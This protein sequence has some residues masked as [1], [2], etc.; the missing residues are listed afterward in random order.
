M[1]ALVTAIDLAVAALNLV[2]FGGHALFPFLLA[3]AGNEQRRLW[4]LAA[5][6]LLGLSAIV[7]AW[8]IGQRPDEA[9]AWGL[10]HPLTGSAP[11]RMIAV[12]FVAAALSDLLTLVLW[13]KLEPAAWRVHGAIGAIALLAQ[14]LGAELLRI[15]WGPS[16]AT[17]ALLASAALRVP[18]ALAAAEVAIGAPR[19]FALAA[20][21]ALVLLAL[22]WP[23]AMRAALVGDLATL[24]A[25]VGLLALARF[26]PLSLRRPAAIAGVVLALLFL[27]RSAE[28]SSV[29]GTREQLHE[30]EL[31]P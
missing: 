12:A 7:T 30:F 25:A 24:A 31:A 16:G 13:P 6:P 1:N 17:W 5:L 23:Q 28:L 19:R 27:T 20:A 21:P 22:L 10:T 18:L 14:S 4:A 11:A 2:V 26:V 15:G 8:S 29:L 9:I 3:R